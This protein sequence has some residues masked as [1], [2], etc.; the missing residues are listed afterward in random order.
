M[1]VR[2]YVFIETTPGK[3]SQVAEAMAKLPGVKVAH[4]VTGSYDIIAFVEVKDVA[5]LGEF[6]SAR[7]HRLPG[8][9]RTTTNVVL[10]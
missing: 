5:A 6:V 4:P 10:D 8:V 9:L 1:T 3:P 2:A 7:L